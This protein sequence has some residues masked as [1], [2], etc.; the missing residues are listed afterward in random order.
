MERGEEERKGPVVLGLGEGEEEWSTRSGG[1]A[2]RARDKDG[3]PGADVATGGG[4]RAYRW[5]PRV[6]ER[7][8]GSGDGWAGSTVRLGFRFSFFFFFYISN[9]NI[10]KY[11]LKYFQKS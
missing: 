5:G 8:R 4:R 6:R 1:C 10:D 2:A 11:I 9:K 3:Q 7:E